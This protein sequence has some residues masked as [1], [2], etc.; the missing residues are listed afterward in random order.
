MLRTG[1]KPQHPKVPPNNYRQRWRFWFLRGLTTMVKSPL[2]VCIGVSDGW[3]VLALLAGTRICHRG[4]TGW[5]AN[6]LIVFYWG[7]PRKSIAE[8]PYAWCRWFDITYDKRHD[9]PE[10]RTRRHWN[11]RRLWFVASAETTRAPWREYIGLMVANTQA[12]FGLVFHSGIGSAADIK[13]DL[14]LCAPMM[15]DRTTVVLS[16][17]EKGGPATCYERMLRHDGWD[18]IQLGEMGILQR[19]AFPRRSD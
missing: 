4:F 17:L 7:D 8:E 10:K 14:D 16:G 18:G 3:D 13:A 19:R 2:Y 6:R 5:Y 9:P 11:R 15:D 1:T 12:R